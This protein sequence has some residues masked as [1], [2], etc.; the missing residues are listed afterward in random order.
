M[1]EVWTRVGI[2]REKGWMQAL[3]R[4]RTDRFGLQQMRDSEEEAGTE[5]IL[6]WGS[7]AGCAVP[8]KGHLQGWSLADIWE[9]RFQDGF[10]CIS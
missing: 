2:G 7:R 8:G 6:V 3:L 1:T 4:A 5:V 9:L 10:P